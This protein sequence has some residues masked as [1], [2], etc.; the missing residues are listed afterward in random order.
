MQWKGQAALSLLLYPFLSFFFLILSM[1]QALKTLGRKAEPTKTSLEDFPFLLKDL[2]GIRAA[3]RS[4]V[5]WLLS[6]D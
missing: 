4:F 6:I 5:S 1:F 3:E 2:N